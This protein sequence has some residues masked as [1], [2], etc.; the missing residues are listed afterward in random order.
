[1]SQH[2]TYDTDIITLRRIFAASPGSNVPVQSDYVLTTGEYGEAKFINPL[3]ISSIYAISSLVSILPSG[4][5]SLS[6][7][8]GDIDI[9]G[10]KEG[11]SSLSTA[12]QNAGGTNATYTI[13]SV[14]TVYAYGLTIISSA[15]NVYLNPTG[16]STQSI[17]AGNAFLSSLNFIDSGGFGFLTVN[18]GV[19]Y[20]NGSP[21]QGTIT[22]ANITSTV[23]GLGTTGYVS[24]LS[25][26]I[27]SANLASLVSTNY[28]ATQL[29]STVVGLGSAGYL[30][31]LPSIGGFVSTANLDGL[32]SSANLANLVS[33]SYLATQLTSTV[34][35][36]GTAGY[37]ST[38]QLLSTSYGLSQQI[39]NA[40]GSA[41]T[42]ATLTSTVIGLGTV[43]YISSS[44]LLSTSA[45]LVALIQN[46]PGTVTTANLTSTVVG[47]GSAG[48]L[49]TLPSIGGFVSTANLVN[50]VSTSYFATQLGSTVVGL[51]SAGYLSTIFSTN[52]YDTLFVNTI[53]SG[54]V[55]AYSITA[56]IVSSVTVEA[57]FIGVVGNTSFFGDGN[58]L[59]NL[60][61]ANI[62]G[63]LP[64]TAYGT[65]S[66]PLGS[67]NPSGNL[68]ITGNINAA[69]LVNLVSTSYFDSQL[70]STV[71]G[72]GTVGY[73]STATLLSTSYGLAA[74][75]Q[76][77]PGSVTTANLT[78]TVIGLG[79]AGY[80][81]SATTAI[82]PGGLVSTSF[83]D[84]QLTSTVIGLGSAGYLSSAT[85]A[86]LPGGLVSTSYFDSQLTSTVIGLGS[87][88]YLS[89]VTTVLLEGL[90]STANL[91]NLISTAN[92]AN[93]ISTSFFDTQLTSTV[94]GLG[95]AGYLSSGFSSLIASSFSSSNASFQLLT[96]SSILFGTGSGYLTLPNTV[97]PNLSVGILYASTIVGFNPGGGSI[98]GGLVS[99]S[100][101]DT[102]LTSTVIGLGTA[103]YLSTLLSTNQYDI[104]FVN[105]IS[106]GQVFVSSIRARIVSSVTVE[107][108]TIGVTGN[109]TFY[110]DATYLQNLTAANVVGIL[111]YTVYG[112]GSIPL[113]SIN[114]NGN[115][116]ITG[117]INAANLLG[118][119]STANLTNLISTANL[120]NLISTSFFD[121]QLTS[122]VIG[123]GSAGYLSTGF[124]S[125]IA[126]SF[127][128]SNA[129][130]QLLTTSS[131]LFGTGSGY[132]TL[133]NTVIPN[134]SVGI[135]YA[136]TIVGFNPGGGSIIG[137]LVSTSYLD[138]QLTST[139]IGLGTVG[140]LS[141]ITSIG[142]FVSTANLANLISTANLANLISTSFF[143]IQL[144]STVVG[145][146]TAGY[147]STLFNVTF[148]SSVQA[149][150]SSFS[151]NL[152]DALTLVLYDM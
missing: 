114:P 22:Q 79:S 63:T 4:I 111:P 127:S 76:N 99:T 123:L 34:I 60:A 58:Q 52:Q 14:D 81:S 7:V 75:I 149:Q 144:G 116:T 131:I 82:I 142:G 44:Q 145:L 86:V 29:G 113:G 23:V 78:S 39:E 41:V 17:S 73:V 122:T 66:I 128:S 129:S 90:V 16:I 49:S 54:Q 51:G 152:A 10:L 139:V 42:P 88:G 101:L 93:L 6:T 89:S 8:I 100:Y 50:L 125:L 102:Q 137:G 107:A 92:V 109:T 115:L 27:S 96:T 151:G 31:T 118:L 55:R 1:M 138:T 87:A 147:V 106:S 67:I 150:A 40:P 108:G 148:I 62:T 104:L 134:L 110:G 74:L 119:V 53:S 15:T 20:L 68:M 37:I 112:T 57:A 121:T 46:P 71:I 140:Y 36:L 3:S 61:G 132:L 133:P 117:N 143:D 77:A 30:S 84:S 146:G 124:S 141:S 19:L 56:Q 47:L 94:V 43:G 65:G 135:L 48:Y 35:G 26:L 12:I 32:V 126:S 13:S 2:K 59:Q 83:L 25:D 28:L 91:A 120:A 21:I 11:L 95:S 69:N 70:T 45:G 5:S 24:S 33:T 105:T 72:L 103:G 9:D 64:Y 98:I 80:L 18:S 136:S 85:T 38:S 97:I 130:F